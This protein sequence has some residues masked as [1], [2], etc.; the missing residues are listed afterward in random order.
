MKKPLKTG[1]EKKDTTIRERADLFW[2]AEADI[3][4]QEL[5]RDDERDIR[6]LRTN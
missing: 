6:R 5:L 3:I 2:E 1:S 4:R